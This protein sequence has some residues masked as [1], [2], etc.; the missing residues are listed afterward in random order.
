MRFIEEALY[1]SPAWKPALQ[2]CVLQ[3]VGPEPRRFVLSTPL[4]GSQPNDLT[5]AIPFADPVWDWLSDASGLVTDLDV[6]AE[7]LGVHKSDA[8]RL[9]ALLAPAVPQPT[10]SQVP[11]AAP[12][13]SMS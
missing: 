1:R 3:P 8:H 4:L 10:T 11:S 12:Q 7:R 6:A 2:T 5:L 13:T 9:A